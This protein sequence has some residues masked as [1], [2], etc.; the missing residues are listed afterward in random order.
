MSFNLQAE[1]GRGEWGSRE[2][3][4]SQFGVKTRV[5]EIAKRKLPWDTI[6]V[7]HSDCHSY[8]PTLV[9][10]GNLYPVV[11]DVALVSQFLQDFAHLNEANYRSR[12]QL[13]GAAVVALLKRPD[14]WLRGLRYLRYQIGQL[15]ADFIRARG[16]VHKLTYFMQNFMDARQLDQERVNAC[17]FM[18]M[19][20]DGPVSMCE[21]N[22]RRDDFILKP[23]TVTNLDGSVE[24][25]QPLVLKE[26]SRPKAQ[27]QT[28]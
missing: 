8:L 10:N 22:A 23:L 20:A 26:Y 16:K 4:V 11:E 5:E 12:K 24:E 21:H 2:S 17:S 27:A 9:V 19:T 1:T 18:V 14:W 28:I 3:L 6:R 7:G 15:G 13:V 25:Y